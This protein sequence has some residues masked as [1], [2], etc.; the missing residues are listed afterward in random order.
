MPT[1]NVHNLALGNGGPCKL[2][3]VLRALGW[4]SSDWRYWRAP[5]P[6]TRPNI[7]V[8]QLSPISQL[9]NP[10][11]QPNPTTQPYNPTQQ[12]NPTTQPNNPALQPNPA[13]QPKL[14]LQLS[15]SH[16]HACLGR[17]SLK[18]AIVVTVLFWRVSAHLTAMGAQDE[19]S[20]LCWRC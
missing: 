19:E 2:Q 4:G 15:V 13:T 20:P 9:N 3:Q 7:P 10:T 1:T 14:R 8:Q 5:N 18:L 12:P 17:P 11:Q 6:T 16:P